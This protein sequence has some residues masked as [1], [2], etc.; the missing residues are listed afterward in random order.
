MSGGPAWIL[1]D[2]MSL[3]TK[4]SHGRV[5]ECGFSVGWLLLFPVQ[6]PPLTELQTTQKDADHF[7]VVFI[8]GGINSL[9]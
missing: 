7:K 2:G 1:D 4:Y 6:A 3:S 5:V 9:L 8:G